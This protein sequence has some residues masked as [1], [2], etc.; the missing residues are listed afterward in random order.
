MN[1]KQE[2]ESLENYNVAVVAALFRSCFLLID[3][4]H[5]SLLLSLVNFT[6]ELNIVLFNGKPS[7]YDLF[8]LPH[9]QSCHC[10]RMIDV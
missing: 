8:S 9:L 4:K 3:V 7:T 10:A 5:I 2:F 6:P 1:H